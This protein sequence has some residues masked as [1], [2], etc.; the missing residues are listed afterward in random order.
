[1]ITSLDIERNGFRW[2]NIDTI[3]SALPVGEAVIVNTD[4]S[5][6]NGVHWMTLVRLNEKTYYL[7]D[8]LGPKNERVESD[9]SADV[10]RLLARAVRPGIV[11]HY[12]HAVQQHSDVLC[13]FHALYVAGLI[14]DGANWT[15]AKLTK[16]IDAHYIDHRA[17]SDDSKGAQA[18]A[19]VLSR[20]FGGR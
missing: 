20:A 5:S 1:M 11:N 9:G 10:D 4:R 17:K 8:P 13:G 3:P 2:F 19:L 18:N 15:P 14:R 6:G 7:F 16:A 12:P